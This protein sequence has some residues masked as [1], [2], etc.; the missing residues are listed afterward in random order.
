LRKYEAEGDPSGKKG[1]RRELY[2]EEERSVFLDT[3][4]GAGV[5]FAVFYSDNFGG[6]R[7]KET[8]VRSLRI[9]RYNRELGQTVSGGMV[10]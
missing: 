8:G 9:N 4:R 6:K 3:S 10:I 1:H 2:P 5:H 7:Y